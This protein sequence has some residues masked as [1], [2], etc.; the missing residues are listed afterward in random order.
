ME[1]VPITSHMPAITPGT[2]LHICTTAQTPNLIL[3]YTEVW[4][5]TAWALD[6]LLGLDMQRESGR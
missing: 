6:L 5:R 4:A 3:L 1:A 2:R